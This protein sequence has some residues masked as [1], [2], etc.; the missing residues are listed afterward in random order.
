MCVDIKK[1]RETDRSGTRCC[2]CLTQLC[3]VLPVRV[4]LQ[5]RLQQQS[6]QVLQDLDSAHKRSSQ[7]LQ[8]RV[9]QL[10]VSCQELSEV[11]F[12]NESLIRELKVK[13]VGAEEVNE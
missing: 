1:K 9:S 6:E 11:K 13:L 10:E 5:K 8:C 12:R 3:R 7:Q 4:Q 2:L